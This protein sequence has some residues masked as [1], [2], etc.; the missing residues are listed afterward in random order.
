MSALLVTIDTCVMREVD[1]GS[2]T[3]RVLNGVAVLSRLRLQMQDG[4][5]L[6]LPL[7]SHG[8]KVLY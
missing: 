3:E 6:L 8:P 5:A 7:G 2:D 1:E 4:L